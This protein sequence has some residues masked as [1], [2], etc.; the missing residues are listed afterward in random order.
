[1][2]KAKQNADRIREEQYSMVCK[3]Y[4]KGDIFCFIV[5]VEEET[6]TAELI[7]RV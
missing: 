4:F 3:G 6:L 5:R 1:M 2:N 7:A